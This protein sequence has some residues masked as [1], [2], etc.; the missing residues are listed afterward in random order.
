MR[1]HQRGLRAGIWVSGRSTNRNQDT[2]ACRTKTSTIEHIER[3][4]CLLS[5]CPSCRKFC[6]W[7]RGKNTSIREATHRPPPHESWPSA[8]RL[9]RAERTRR[10]VREKVAER[11]IDCRAAATIIWGL[12]PDRIADKPTSTRSQTLRSPQAPVSREFGRFSAAAAASHVAP[13]P[14][15]P[16]ALV[17]AAVARGFFQMKVHLV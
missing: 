8:T 15:E 7:S 3:S 14:A 9:R 10:I 5:L 12:V 16:A 2:R 6:Y 4:I 1:Q 13:E 11:S 17:G